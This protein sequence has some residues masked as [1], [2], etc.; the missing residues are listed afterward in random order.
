MF[1]DTLYF[2]QPQILQ[3]RIEII[4]HGYEFWDKYRFQSACEAYPLFDN[5]YCIGTLVDGEFTAN[6]DIDIRI[7]QEALND[8]KSAI[9][10]GLFGSF[11]LCA[12][13]ESPDDPDDYIA[14]FPWHPHRG[15]ET[16]T[17]MINILDETLPIT[18]FDSNTFNESNFI[19]LSKWVSKVLHKK[20]IKRNKDPL[21]YV[22]G[23]SPIKIVGFW[24]YL[25]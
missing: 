8:L 9:A 13:I 7:P 20:N 19:S 6:K 2:L 22:L 10:S 15:I 16:I 3:K 12:A 11:I 1:A 23:D 25:E 14:G 21:G 17:Y 5:W 18:Y 4:E 24:A